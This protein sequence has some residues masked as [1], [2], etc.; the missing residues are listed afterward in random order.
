MSNN[1]YFD[2]DCPKCKSRG[3][4]SNGDTSDL[5]V[6]DVER[7]KCWKCGVVINVPESID[8]PFTIADDQDDGADESMPMPARK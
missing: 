6:G 7:F 1:S 8:D 5:T 4:V 3:L 2:F